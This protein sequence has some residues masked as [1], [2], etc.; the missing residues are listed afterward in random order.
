[1]DIRY[2]LNTKGKKHTM[3]EVTEFIKKAKTFYLGTTDGE[4]P[5]VRPIGVFQEYDGKLY[6]A[7][8][9]HKNVYAQI[10]KNPKVVI[11]ALGDGGKWIRLRA[12]AMKATEEIVTKVFD[13]NPFLRSIYNEETGRQLGVVELTGATVEF[14]GMMGPER[15]ETL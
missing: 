15:T 12:T 2:K 3:H 7:V 9:Q 6:T 10:L 8:G 14:C 1:M 5:E 4:Q 13:D 11:C